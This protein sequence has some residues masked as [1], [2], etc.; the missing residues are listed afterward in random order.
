MT[1]YKTTLL[2]S[3]TQ[4]GKEHSSDIFINRNTCNN[5]NFGYQ[6]NISFLLQMMICAPPYNI[7]DIVGT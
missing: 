7:L 5:D 1:T 2:A 3:T 6:F 4:A